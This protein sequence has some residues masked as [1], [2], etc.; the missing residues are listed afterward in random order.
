[1]CDTLSL[2]GLF[3]STL[4][5]AQ[6]RRTHPAHAFSSNIHSTKTLHDDGKVSLIDSMHGIYLL[7]CDSSIGVPLS[8]HC[9]VVALVI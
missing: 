2:R 9:Y 6:L 4:L 7:M 8:S 5:G 1:M 3:A